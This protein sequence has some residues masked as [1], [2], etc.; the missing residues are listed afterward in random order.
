[1][2]VSCCCYRYSISFLVATLLSRITGLHCVYF[3]LLL[4]ADTTQFGWHLLIPTS[5]PACSIPRC[6][7]WCVQPFS[8][9]AVP[10]VRSATEVRCVPTVQYYRRAYSMFCNWGTLRLHLSDSGSVYTAFISCTNS[11]TL[12][13]SFVLC[14]S[15]SWLFELRLHIYV[16]T[17]T[18]IH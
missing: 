14:F 1:M 4:S 9:T 16:I 10:T 18:D 11:N 13:Y 17:S 12:V 7:A 5:F 3:W 2:T 8:T 15:T 6:G